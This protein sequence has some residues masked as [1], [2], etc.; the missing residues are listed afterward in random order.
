MKKELDYFMI[1]KS[2]GGN[3][4]WFIDFMMHI[5][6]CAAE[7]ACDTCIYLA[8]RFG[9]AW[10]YPYD[11]QA[12]NRRDYVRFARGMKPYL[13]PRAG[14]ID[15]LSIYIDG[16]NAYL[17]DHPQHVSA[18]CEGSSDTSMQ[19]PKENGGGTNFR[20]T[21]AGL[22]GDRPAK[23][24]WQAVRKQIDSGLPVPILILHHQNP[25]M[26]DYVWH[27]FLL[28]GYEELSGE[29]AAALNEVDEGSAATAG[30]RRV[31]AVTYGEYQWLDFDVLWNTGEEP[32]G[33]LILY[34]LEAH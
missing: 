27:W 19:R 6:G 23:E 34:S 15:K 9:M 17:Q 20:V 13:R 7:T 18:T 30:R 16:F 31:K 12:L 21:M 33:G 10:L 4:S 29:D 1:G 26:K 24:A 8:R 22:D 5:G 3:Q 32:K 2:Y 28:T 11:C 14:G 25:A